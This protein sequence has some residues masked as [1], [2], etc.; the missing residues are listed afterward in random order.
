MAARSDLDM[1]H[2]G[3]FAKVK[4][5]CASPD[6]LGPVDGT[7]CNVDFRLRSLKGADFISLCRCGGRNLVGEGEDGGN[8]WSAGREGE[9]L[10]P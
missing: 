3:L 1:S 8:E 10:W 5:G 7:S 4:F 6:E 9:G 2:M